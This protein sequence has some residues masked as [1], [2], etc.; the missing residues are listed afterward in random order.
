MYPVYPYYGKKEECKEKP[1][2]FP[3]QH[4]DVQPGLEYQMVPRPISEDPDY[5]G[6]GKLKGKVAI[7]TGGD[8]GIGRAAAYSFVKGK[9]TGA[10]RGKSFYRRRYEKGGLFPGNCRKNASSFRKDRYPRQ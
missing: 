3:P 2:S 7:I 9:D 4:Q 10:W 5:R 8:S 6:S 1:L